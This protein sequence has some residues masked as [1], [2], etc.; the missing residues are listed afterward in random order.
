MFQELPKNMD[1][2]FIGEVVRLPRVHHHLEWNAGAHEFIRHFDRVLW[3]HI[4]VAQAMSHEEMSLQ[5]P[6]KPKYGILFV[7]IFTFG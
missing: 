3:M 7:A 5:L 4:D 2:G 6:S 1:L